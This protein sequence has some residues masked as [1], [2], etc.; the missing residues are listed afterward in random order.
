MRSLHTAL[1]RLTPKKRV[2]FTLWAL[3]G[4]SPEEIAELTETP[5]HTVRSRIHAAR[6]ELMASPRVRALLE[7]R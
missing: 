7:E 1:E 6:H 2:A 4:M 3:D 5:V